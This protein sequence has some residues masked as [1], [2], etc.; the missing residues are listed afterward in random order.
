MNAAEEN[1]KT[2]E[3]VEDSLASALNSALRDLAARGVNLWVWEGDKP[4]KITVQK[5]L[6]LLCGGTYSEGFAAPESEEYVW[7]VKTYSQSVNEELANETHI[8]KYYTE[9]VISTLFNKLK[10][11]HN[12]ALFRDYPIFEFMQDD[13]LVWARI[14]IRIEYLNVPTEIARQLARTNDRIKPLDLDAP[15]THRKQ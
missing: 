8:F 12:T 11:P 9:K 7:Q 5:H 2:I 10:F 3:F 4:N 6:T 14:R 1:V 13:P 15:L